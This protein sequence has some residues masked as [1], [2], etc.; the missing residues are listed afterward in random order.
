MPISEVFNIDNMIYF[1]TCKDKQFSLGLID[2]PYG[3]KRDSGFGGFGEPIKR[4]EYEGWGDET[5][6]DKKYFDEL[7]R[8]C[9][10]VIIWGGQ[11]FTDKLPQSGHWIFWD[12]INTMPTFG[13]GELAYTNFD[14][15]SVKRF[16]FQYNGLLGKEKE[17]RINATQKPIQLYKWL[18]KNYAK[19]GD[20]IFDANMGSQASRIASHE[21]GFDFYGCEIDKNQFEAGCKRFEIYKSQL[22]IAF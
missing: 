18:L 9:V 5:T 6:P 1:K 21:G 8:I 7:L 13:D 17:K 15:G 20:I 22:K 10:H 14:R 4:K 19:E 3:I 11:F 16:V 12:K 2:P